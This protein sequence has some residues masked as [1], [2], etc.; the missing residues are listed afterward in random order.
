MNSTFELMPNELKKMNRAHTENSNSI[1]PHTQTK[2]VL[3]FLASIIRNF[4][5]VPIGYGHCPWAGHDME[6]VVGTLPTLLS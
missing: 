1:P 4:E 3:L 5:M 6:M 2:H